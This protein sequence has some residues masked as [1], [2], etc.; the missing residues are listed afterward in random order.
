[1]PTWQT[2]IASIESRVLHRCHITVYCINKCLAGSLII[3][4]TIIFLQLACNSSNIY[5]YYQ[6]P[7]LFIQF[8]SELLKLPKHT[9]DS[10]SQRKLYI[11]ILHYFKGGASNPL[12]AI[13]N[14]FFFILVATACTC[15]LLYPYQCCAGGTHAAHGCVMQMCEPGLDQWES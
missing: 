13:L 8:H 6:D 14:S 1:M 2:I 5:A 12:L 10:V 3:E 9:S 15:C 4:N 7:V 11:L